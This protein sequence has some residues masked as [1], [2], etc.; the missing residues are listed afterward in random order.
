MS[1]IIDVRGPFEGMSEGDFDR[2]KSLQPV[3]RDPS[4]APCRTAFVTVPLLGVDPRLR[5]RRERESAGRRDGAR[6]CRADAYR[7]FNQ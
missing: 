1:L 4:G 2:N 5:A 3:A 6:R 7:R